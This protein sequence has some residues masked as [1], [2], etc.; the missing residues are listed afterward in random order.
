M[1]PTTPN[2]PE[3]ENISLRHLW[4]FMAFSLPYWPLL[5]AGVVTGLARMGLALFMPWYV[6]YIID[7][8][9]K[10]FVD[11][12]ITSE[13]AWSRM[14]W[15]STLLGGVVVV[16]WAASLGRFYFPHR[17]AANAIRD[18]RYELF[19]HLQR[20]SLGFHTQRPTGG[21][22]ARVI[23][24]VEAAQQAFDMIMVQLSQAVLRASAIMVMLLWLDWQWALVA[25]ATTPL[26]VITTRLLRRPMRRA[27]RRQRETVERMSG[28]V[29]ERFS[30]IRE[31]QSFTAEDHEERQVLDEA[32]QLRRH[33]I[34]QRLLGGLLHSASEITRIL[35]LA[36]VLTFGV[37]RIT[38]GDG[39]TTIGTLPLFFMYSGQILQPMQFFA[40]LYTR[41]HISA[42]AADRVFDFF[43]TEPNITSRRDAQPLQINGAPTVR[44]ENVSFCY[45]TETPVVVLEE[46][47]FKAEPGSKVVLV[48]ESGGG[49]STLMS[50]LPRFYDVR[51]GRILIDGQDVRDVQLPSLRRAIA[52]VPQEPV[53]FSGSIRENILYGRQGSSD[54]EIHAAARA[55]NADRFILETEDGYDA[56]VGERGVG[57]SG[58]QIQRIAIARAFLKEPAVLI[59]DEPTSNLDALSE[60]LVMEALQRLAHGRTTFVIAHRLSIARDADLIVVLDNGRIV[61]TGG[62]DEL[63][64]QNGPYA[65]LWQQQVGLPN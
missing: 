50:L 31:V 43:D 21:I 33:T 36:I 54:D 11:G 7:S 42:A 3:A 56:E 60:S 51:G 24:D 20:L 18:A 38:S 9:G 40:G 15:I 25:L 29:Q 16:H 58:G 52:V 41:L 12:L 64:D 8:V 37:W 48:G 45:P 34:R 17:A 19:R 5:A 2:S 65:R 39:E 49:K 13:Q 57:L 62:H 14:G 55:A 22:V 27:S 10:P 32:E 4:R 28:L 23:A 35:G 6:K 47:D 44:F 1:S 61:E 63:L 30:M 53:L 46:I 26:F 59:M